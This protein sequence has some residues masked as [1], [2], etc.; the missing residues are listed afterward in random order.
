MKGRVSMADDKEKVDILLDDDSSGDSP[1]DK[2]KVDIVLDE[3]IFEEDVTPEEQMKADLAT[4]DRYINIAEHMK[5]FEDQDKY[6]TRAIKYIRKARNY[7]RDVEHDEEL[8][9]VY[10]DA[11]RKLGRKKFTI[12]SEGKIA[13]YE[14]A[15]NVR[16]NAKT[17]SDYQNAHNIFDRIHKYEIKHPINEKWVTPELYEKTKSCEDSEEQAK[18]CLQ[19]AGDKTKRLRR[20]SL[21]VSLAVIACIVAFLAFARTIHFRRILGMTESAIGDNEGAWQAYKYVLDHGDDSIFDTYIKTRYQAGLDAEKRKDIPTAI[22]DFRAAATEPDKPYK[23]SDQRLVNLEL[24][25]LRHPEDYESGLGQIIAFGNMNWRILEKEDDR[26]FLL[27]DSAMHKN[28]VTGEILTFH[29]HETDQ[30]TW[31]NSSIRQ[32]LNDADSTD[33]EKDP[34]GFLG[35]QFT[36]EERKLIL[37]TELRG[38]RNND[39]NIPAGNPTVDKVFLLTAEEVKYY[40]SMEPARIPKSETNWWIRTPGKYAGSMAFVNP[41]RTVMSY[42]YEA[43]ADFCTI[44]PCMWVDISK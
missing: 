18:L 37:D 42:G 23:D 33:P 34:P 2:D 7:F 14:E 6:Y 11:I 38:A 15:C 30:L 10:T 36:D 43:S 26:V 22:G 4:A 32:W 44:K 1:Y 28:Q 41:E 21:I 16:D 35:A 9:E 25:R 13:L 27:K 39:Y 19:M 8:A 17:P 40:S 12:R 24:E 31:E 5:Q 3:K 29:D 20:H